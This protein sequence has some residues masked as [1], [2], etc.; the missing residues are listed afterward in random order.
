M[1]A[2]PA[3]PIRSANAGEFDPS[4][5][6]RVDIKQYYSGGLAFKNIEPV[7]QGGW[8]R[9][10]GSR[11]IGRWRKPLV[12]QPISSA[13]LIPGPHSGVAVIWTGNIA[14][15]V[16]AVL[17]AGLTISTGSATFSVEARISGVWQ[18][19]AG[20]FAIS[21]AASVTR[22]AAFAPGAQKTADALRVVAIVSGPATVS[23]MIVSA[24]SE[25][26]TPFRPRY[27]SLTTDEGD[28][29]SC[30][31]SASIADFWTSEGYKGAAWLEN[32]TAA[33]LPDL[34]FYA[35]GRTVGIFHS[36]LPSVRL[37]LATASNLHDWR[38]DLWPYDPP[39]KA[40][41][42]GTYSK[43]NDVW[44]IVV[45]WSQSVEMQM[46]VT[47]N[48]EVTTSVPHRNA[49]GDI[50]LSDAF[51]NE[52]WGLFATALQNALQSLP[53]FGLG[54]TVSQF[55]SAGKSRRLTITFGGK[56]AGSE[57]QVSALVV[58]TTEMSALPYHTEFGRTNLEPLFSTNRG[59]PGTAALIQ[60]RMGHARIPAATG[61]L[62][63]SKV[64]EYFDLNAEAKTDNAAR[65]DRL[66]SIT[67]ETILA[68]VESTYLFVF[69]NRGVYFVPNRTIERNTPLNFVKC[70]EVG[71]QPNCRPFVMEGG[72]HY[73]AIAESGLQNYAVGG[74][75]LLR[76]DESAVTSNTSFAA[77]P[78]SLLA[79]HLVH[80][81]IRDVRQNAQNDLDASKGWLM[82]AD[83]RLICGQMIRN[84]E[85]TGFC[86]WIPAADGKAREIGVDGKNRLWV[87]VDRTGEGTIEIYDPDVYLQDAVTVTTDLAGAVNSVPYEEG[88]KLW[89]VADGYVLGP[90][91]VTGGSIA[92]GDP[93]ANV[94]IGRWQ[95]SRFET[96]PQVYVT[97]GD[98]VVLRPGRIHTVSANIIDT[99]SIAIGANGEAPEDIPLGRIGDPVNQ[100]VPAKT[101]LL[102]VDGL[103][104]MKESTTA[105]ITQLRPGELYVR[106][107]SIGAKL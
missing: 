96:M 35:E 24:Y 46:T 106:D 89:A 60:D 22:L 3:T 59:W 1:V 65:L 27:V 88:A 99:T 83:G 19:I 73:V 17:C 15:P 28:V 104:G 23:G 29:L 86:E 25:G 52:T 11:R 53:S 14:G 78:V 81:V 72:L 50:I 32:V 95:A 36:W 18:Q 21:S 13:T 94:D 4:A 51:T 80:G 98:D 103:K 33:M 48:G 90:F 8:R 69:T 45:R 79:S 54:V 75:Q 74:N 85:I 71:I 38:A 47:V 63:L 67:S 93:Y 42:G 34:D 66:R 41:L 58:N 61:A 9:M 6:G 101:M 76:L 102:E 68:L 57:Y 40:D 82:R 37:F 97:P 77:N 39:P 62:A 31:V 100:P 2:R 107:I 20:P 49:A 5:A 87:A 26:G 56:Y 43:T 12:N 10:G 105:V 16:A 84:Q 7:P 70:S 44:D 64:G 91:T 30:F 55:A 92:L